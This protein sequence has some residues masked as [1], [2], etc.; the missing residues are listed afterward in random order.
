VISLFYAGRH[1]RQR[2]VTQLHQWPVI[3]KRETEDKVQ[4]AKKEKQ[5]STSIIIVNSWN[6]ERVKV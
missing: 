1:A 4:I 2:V 6:N 3:C 5:H